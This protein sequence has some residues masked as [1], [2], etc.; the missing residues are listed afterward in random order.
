MVASKAGEKKQGIRAVST[1][2][3]AQEQQSRRPSVRNP[4]LAELARN[5]CFAAAFSSL[6]KPERTLLAPVRRLPVSF[7]GHF[8]GFLNPRRR[9]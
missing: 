5:L 8:S 7:P 2:S 1:N 3:E 9:Y 4:N 6:P